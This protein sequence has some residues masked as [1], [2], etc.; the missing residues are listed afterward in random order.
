[1]PTQAPL[2]TKQPLSTSPKMRPSPGPGSC[3]PPSAKRWDCLHRGLEGEAFDHGGWQSSALPS[4]RKTP[5]PPKGLGLGGSG[6]SSR[7][8]TG[9]HL[10]RERHSC[11][12]IPGLP[13]RWGFSPGCTGGARG[14]RQLDSE[15]TTCSLPRPR[16][17]HARGSA[18]FF[19]FSLILVQ[20]FGE[21][22]EES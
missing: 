9:G 4:P 6:G 19:I 1:M 14:R 21:A 3:G 11:A 22:G 5:S 8:T 20:E 17:P 18:L 2:L 15:E 12:V 10:C 13:V 16:G 7:A